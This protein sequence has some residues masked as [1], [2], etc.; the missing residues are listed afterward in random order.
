MV[1]VILKDL[2]VVSYSCLIRPIGFKAKEKAN[3]II[4]SLTLFQ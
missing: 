3:N 4:M 2:E 1:I